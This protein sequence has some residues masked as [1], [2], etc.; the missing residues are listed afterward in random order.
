MN[1]SD[2]KI[3]LLCIGKEFNVALTTAVADHCK[4]SHLISGSAFCFH[5]N[6][7]PV[8]LISFSWKCLIAL[9]TASLTGY[10]LTFCWNKILIETGKNPSEI[11]L[12]KLLFTIMYNCFSNSSVLFSANFSKVD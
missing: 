5:I 6:K 3:F 10:D 12:S 11:E 8:H 4:T 2:K 7:A 1:H 9:S